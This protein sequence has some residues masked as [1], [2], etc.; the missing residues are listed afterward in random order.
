M[1]KPVAVIVGV[2]PGNGESLSR[3]F[4]AE[5]HAVAMLARGTE[6]TKKLA[7]EIEDARAYACD[8]SDAAAVASAFAAIRR[9]MG[10][11]ETVVY[12]A[13]SGVWG[14]IEEIDADGFEKSWRVN[15]LGAFLVAK[16][17]TP[18]MQKAGRGSFV[19]IGATASLRGGAGTAAFAPA[20]A[21]QRSLAQSMARHLWPKGVHVALI[22]IDG[23]V[24]LPRTR[25]RSPEKPDD[26]FVDPDGVAE[27]AFWLT[28]QPRQ[29]WS[30]EVEARPFGE[31]W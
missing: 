31:K 15:A 13:G 2:G 1:A 9:D 28:R 27:T 29:A 24:D 17:A 21:A 16:E 12:N 10:E 25:Q 7:G 30:F 6:L 11:P 26:F 8:V 14:S 23:V 20:K 5:G 4:A 3:R 19:F 18:A 22:V